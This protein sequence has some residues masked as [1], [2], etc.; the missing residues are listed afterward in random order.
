M[1]KFRISGGQAT[2]N[3]TTADVLSGKTFMSSGSP[4]EQTGS[5]TNNG[6]VTETL[7]SNGQVYTIPAGYH[8]GTGTVTANISNVL[9]L[10][11]L[12]LNPDLTQASFS[13]QTISIDLTDYD[14]VMVEA[15]INNT[16][17]LDLLC[18]TVY[19]KDDVIT[20]PSDNYFAVGY[21][22]DGTGNIKGIGRRISFVS[23]G[24]Y[25]G[26]AILGDTANNT[27]VIPTKIYGVKK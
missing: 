4:A 23:G 20:Q 27:I 9:E 18:R 8:D 16:T 22:I 7:T 21:V 12:W 14:G 25:F 2:G 13:A 1:A 3:A 19:F 6:A 10:T 17:N 11:E 15:R 5:M 24:L 26:N